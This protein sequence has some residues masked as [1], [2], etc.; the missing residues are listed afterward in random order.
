MRSRGDGAAA[1][2]RTLRQRLTSLHARYQPLQKRL[3]QSGES[4][5]KAQAEQAKLNETLTLRRQ[6]YKEK[7]Q[8]YL[9]LKALC[10]P[11]QRLKIW[12]LPFPA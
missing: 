12:K 2:S 1:Q 10:E 11:K 9:D 7:N 3:R 5:Q 6:Q 8:H 4:V